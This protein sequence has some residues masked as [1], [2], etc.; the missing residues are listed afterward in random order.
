MKNSF[1]LKVL[2][3][4]L[5]LM[6]SCVSVHASEQVHKRWKSGQIL[7]KP[8]AGLSDSEFDTVLKGQGGRSI[9]KIGSLDVHIISVPPQAEQSV[10]AALA[11]N[12]KIDFAELDEAVELSA[13]PNDPKFSSAWHLP[14]IQAPIAWDSAKADGVVIAIIDTGVDANHPDLVNQMLPGWNA[15]DQGFDSTDINGH[16]TAVAGTAAA[17]TNNATGVAGIAWNAQILP[18]RISN[19]SDGY[20]YLSDIARGLDWAAKNG[21]KVANISYEVTGSS[22]VN[23]AAK[24]MRSNGGLVVVAG[25]NSGIDPGLADNPNMISVSA[26]DSADNKASWSNF[27]AYID[28]AAPGVSIL[29]TSRGGV[30]G[31]WSGTSFASPA[32][33]G[34][35]AL[36][37]GA[38][39]SL[40][41][42]QVE[43]VL[44]NSADK[45][46]T[47]MP[48]YFGNG[49]INAAKAVQLAISSPTRDTLA[50]TIVINNPINGS[51]VSGNVTILAQAFDNVAIAKMMLYIDSKLFSSV[52]NNASLTYVWNTR[53]T[54]L[55]SHYIKVSAFD[56]ENNVSEKTIKVFK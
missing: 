34:V 32:T 38:N 31:N 23:T 48:T 9:D 21:A 47:T 13:T 45:L 37:M 7:V 1:Y 24:L 26:T 49:R 35:V 52:L 36:I 12:P 42:D 41:P 16:G 25:G 10:M 46:S 4:F 43:T 14:K 33:A 8:K 44:K 51:K 5:L 17:A 15:V 29:T 28:V 56:F 6:F 55:G 39:P 27:G 53:K 50:P 2:S 11:K 3:I 18:V 30:Y 19:S 40:T 20:A 22:S 54:S